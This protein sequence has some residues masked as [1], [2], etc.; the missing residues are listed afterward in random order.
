VS[1]GAGPGEGPRP[2]GERGA[3]LP[4]RHPAA[5]A[6]AVRRA[7]VDAGVALEEVV[8]AA[9]TVLVV[10]ADRDGLDR[11]WSRL[12]DLGAGDPGTGDPGTGGRDATG[13][14]PGIGLLVRYDGEDLD[15]VARATGLGV[16][17]VVAAHHRSAYT[18]EFTGFTPGFAYLTGLPRA[19]HLARRPAPRP[20]VPAG[21]VAIADRY[22]AVYPTS[23][24]GGW[25]LI[26]T[27]VG[28][29]DPAA[30][31]RCHAPVLWDPGR[32]PP[33]RLTPGTSVRFEPAA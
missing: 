19:L 7:A 14:G 26:G 8:P 29:T 16:A 3:L 13:R 4:A 12:A 10:A 22:S 2:V 30:D 24:P 1:G 32:S 28:I 17:E 9:A 31:G 15:A 23:G 11:L 18:A 27:L 21:A 20:R 6:A 5:A 33:A 25:H